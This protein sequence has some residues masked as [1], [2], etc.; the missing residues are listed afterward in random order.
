MAPVYFLKL[1][2]IEGDSRHP[3]HLGELE[4][5]SVAW[6]E[7]GVP[8]REPAT[9]TFTAGSSKASAA[10]FLACAEGRRIAAAVLT[11]LDREDSRQPSRRWRFSDVAVSAYSA[12][13]GRDGTLD[14]VVLRAK[15]VEALPPARR[16]ALRL[17]LLRPDDL[18]NLEIT[19]VNLRLAGETDDQALVVDDPALPARLTVGFPPQTIT[20]TAYFRSSPVPAEDPPP[21]PIAPKPP[22]PP[23]ERDF[24]PPGSIGPARS[25]T[26]RIANPSRLGFDVSDGARLP[27]TIEGLLDWSALRLSVSPLAA[28]PPDAPD[29]QIAAAP[30]IRPPEADETALELPYR[31]LISPNRHV[32]WQHR[33]RPFTSRGRT[34]LWHTRLAVATSH[35]AVEPT[36]AEPAPLRA[37]WSPDY[38]PFDPPPPDAL[39]PHLGLTALSPN[40]RH[41]LVILT[42]AFHGYENEVELS[43]P[44]RL[45]P[46]A[47]AAGRRIPFSLTFPYVPRPFAAEFLML[48]PLGAWLRSRGE[49]EPPRQILRGLPFR[50]DLA[51]M[52]S[53]AAPRPLDS[54][55]AAGLADPG[56]LRSQLG[57]FVRTGEQLDLSEWLHVAAQGRDHYVK[58]VYE[59]EL[60][61]YRNKAAL[62][63]V[64]ERR[65]EESG[66]VVAA[67]QVQQMY[68]V[69]R[70]PEKRF[71]ADDRAMPYKKVNLTT[72]A[73]P[74]IAF[75]Q[76]VV[77]GSRSFWVDVNTEGGS[78]ERFAF[79]GVGTDVTGARSD[80]TVPMMFVSIADTGDRLKQ[81]IAAY[82]ETT[83]ATQLAARDVRIPGQRVAFAE[84]DD[85][86]AKRNTELV[87]DSLNFVVDPQT[88]APKLLRASVKI[89][90]VQSLVG[91]DAA[92]SIRL[93]EDFVAGGFDAATGVFA[94][95]AEPAF[96]PLAD[97]NSLPETVVSS[98]G[99]EFSSDKAGGF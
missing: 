36:P 41:Q 67:Y 89:P 47:G 54:G 9:V 26:G 84:P 18:L 52:F 24:D 51:G 76:Y 78:R 65:F 17:E 83:S 43:L 85:D 44:G 30:A 13:G 32:G 31:L 72:I 12:A 45:L 5:E 81:V 42:S 94:E 56:R 35:G 2:G 21:D 25:S 77:A 28:I 1:D 58:V 69:V 14:R 68:V 62:V 38:S 88:G 74:A 64:T 19:A 61:P 15:L 22:P 71:H 16:P 27:F 37:I 66:G 60:K 90:Q 75:P 34:E 10:L 53:L 92:T 8:P 29:E 48:S 7:F 23:D 70:E 73:T 98:L 80:F 3:E 33:S 40:D 93:F 95:I 86:P 4:L 49:W 55:V 91:S 11:I 46:D 99:V 20:E 39:D 96:G 63:K 82:N 97:Q 59:G 50:P 79:H 57:V 6:G 87:T